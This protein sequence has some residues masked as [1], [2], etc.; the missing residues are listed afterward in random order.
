MVIFGMLLSA[1]LGFAVGVVCMVLLDTNSPQFDKKLPIIKLPPLHFRRETQVTFQRRLDDI[2]NRSFEIA[3]A[4]TTP[5]V[6]YDENGN[7]GVVFVTDVTSR[8]LF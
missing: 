1:T 8:E 5:P 6:R 7:P 3:V 4:N 2:Q